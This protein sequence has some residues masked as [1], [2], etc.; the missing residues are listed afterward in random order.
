MNEIPESYFD[1]AGERPFYARLVELRQIAMMNIAIVHIINFENDDHLD[2]ARYH[3]KMAKHSMKTHYDYYTIGSDRLSALKDLFLAFDIEDE[4]DNEVNENIKSEPAPGKKSGIVEENGF[5]SLETVKWGSMRLLCDNFVQIT[6][7]MELNHLFDLLTQNS[8]YCSPSEQMQSTIQNLIVQLEKD[9]YNDADDGY[10]TILENETVK[11]QIIKAESF[12]KFIESQKYRLFVIDLLKYQQWHEYYSIIYGVLII[13]CGYLTAESSFGPRNESQLSIDLQKAKVNNTTPVFFYGEN[14]DTP[15]IAFL[16]TTPLPVSEG[17]LSSNHAEILYD[18]G[19]ND[20]TAA[21]QNTSN[22]CKLSVTDVMNTWGKSA[23]FFRSS[24]RCANYWVYAL[25]LVVPAVHLTSS[26][27]IIPKNLSSVLNHISPSDKEVE[28]FLKYVEC[29]IRSS[30]VSIGLNFLRVVQGKP[31]FSGSGYYWY[32]VALAN[33]KLHIYKNAEFAINEAEKKSNEKKE[34]KHIAKF[35]EEHNLINNLR[36][37]KINSPV[38]DAIKAQTKERG[39]YYNIISIDGG[40]SLGVIP[41]LLLAEIEHRAKRPIASM[42]NMLAG[43]STGALI[44]AGLAT[45]GLERT[46]LPALTAQEIVELY[47]DKTSIK[48]MF[49]PRMFSVYGLTGP[50]YSAEG[51][52]EIIRNIVGDSRMSSALTSLVIGATNESFTNATTIFNKHSKFSVLDAVMASSAAPTYFP[53]HQIE[54]S[55]FIDGGLQANNPTMHAYEQAIDE[56]ARTDQIR[57]WSLGTGDFI[58]VQEKNANRGLMGWA[59]RAHKVSMYGQSGNTDNFMHRMLKSNYSR[60]QVWFDEPIPMDCSSEW[61][62]SMLVDYA[63]E[64]IEENDDKI[65]ECVKSICDDN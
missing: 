30:K 17:A 55:S 2:L 6:P 46:N 28:T 36:A 34:V 43:T 25:S 35:S 27:E 63:M 24:L 15:K 4:A 14:D 51:R 7:D 18:L 12:L 20:F 23:E 39:S 40:G 41:A 58:Q 64:F 26:W 37:K 65:N 33:R 61:Q 47:T 48:K 8:R 42:V 45:P 3:L 62:I 22:G 52:L 21:A 53:A 60:W 50:L 1:E 11:R 5:E 29:L 10:G 56:K 32:L 9:R 54:S 13:H 19:M 44:A 38:I 16:A 57:I 49:T 59:G 31:E